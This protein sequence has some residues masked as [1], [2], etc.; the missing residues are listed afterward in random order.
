VAPAEHKAVVVDLDTD[1]SEVAVRRRPGQYANKSEELGTTLFSVRNGFSEQPLSFTQA[2][3]H[4]ARHS[5]PPTA[6][7]DGVR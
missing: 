4:S 2:E 6:G 3:P 5:N 1:D 7:R